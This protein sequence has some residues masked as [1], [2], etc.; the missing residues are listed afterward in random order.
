M[1]DS[2]QIYA[3]AHDLSAQM[4]AWRR[5]IHQQPE[6]GLYLPHT[7][8]LVEQALKEM[9]LSPQHIGGDD[10]TGVTALITGKHPGPTILLRADMDAL[11][12]QE[13]NDLPFRSQVPGKSHMCGHDIHTAMLLGAAA[14]LVTN[15]DDMVGNV[16]LMF[17]PG[18]EGYNGASHMIADGLLE[19]PKVD[20]AIAMHCLT[21][22][23]W[24]TGTIL[25]A[26]QGSAKA[27]SDS[28]RIEVRGR[29]THG[30]TP[31]HGIDVV[32][33]LS[34]VTE[35][36]YA[37]RSRELSPFEPAILSVC[38]I[39]AGDADNILP[40]S[41]F[42]S[43]TFR[44]FREDTRTH[45]TQRITEI[46]KQT[47]AAFG[48]EALVSFCGGLHPTLNDPALCAQVS[49]YT[50]ELM[51]EKASSIG[52]VM[53]AE[54]FSEISCRLPSVYLD[55][56]F[57]SA[58]EGYTEAVHSPRCIFNEQALPVGAACYAWCALRWLEDQQT[59]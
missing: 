42:L 23:D 29:G 52:P 16:K 50:Q 18:E 11:P 30:A 47:A 25:C 3:Q 26:T 20:A 55:L 33:I 54:D 56:S 4:I 43:G 39:H 32:N 31:E 9:G 51:E 13:E 58:K 27:S 1:K 12:L 41:G 28:F 2:R 49:K 24:E 35:G 15:R 14:I 46:A 48:G 19:N 37:I 59:Q 34:R 8:H 38:Q 10:V 5:A 40:D 21:G 17:Q 57:G 36:L 7:A 22:S 45:M 44:T 6:V 53:G